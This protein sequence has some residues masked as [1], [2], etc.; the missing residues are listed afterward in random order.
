MCRNE[1]EAPQLY[2]HCAHRERTFIFGEILRIIS[3]VLMPI[4]GHRSKMARILAIVANLRV[5][6][7]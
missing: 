1:V 2:L 6:S 7:L 4:V 5:Q 3:E